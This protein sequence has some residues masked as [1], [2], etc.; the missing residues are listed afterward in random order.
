MLNDPNCTVKPRWAV[1][2]VDDTD[3]WFPDPVRFARERALCKRVFS[4]Y[5]VNLNEVTYCCSLTPAYWC[6]RLASEA[7]PVD[8]ATE[9]DIEYLDS[10]IM[11]GDAMD[12]ERGV[13]FSASR[14]DSAPRIE[15]RPADDVYFAVIELP[16]LDGATEE[17][18]IEEAHANYV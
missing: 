5:L 1:L 14:I 7:E 8:G 4:R 2:I 16:Y 11:D 17:D 18:A 10:R 15:M 6:I 3:C 12:Y 9:E 13:Y